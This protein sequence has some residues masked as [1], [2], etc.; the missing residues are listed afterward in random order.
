MSDTRPVTV[1]VPTVGR[2][3][4]VESC[5]ASLAACEPRAAEV[6]VADQS[7]RDDVREVAKRFESLGV[8]VLPLDVPSKPLA[9]NRALAEAGHEI[10]LVTDDDCTVD[11]AWVGAGWAA[12]SVDADAIVTGRVLPAGEVAAVPS[13]IEAAA[14]RDYTGTLQYGALYGGNMACN[15]TLVLAFGG[16][17]AR[18]EAAEDNDFCYRWLRA[19]RSLRYEPEL[20]VWHHAWR[21]PEELVLNYRAY[22]RGQG[23]FYGKHLR[24][25]DLRVAPFLFRDI[26]RGARGVAARLVRGRS[27]WPDPRTGLLRGVVVGLVRG[28]RSPPR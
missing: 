2:A 24:R 1:V 14:P 25:G 27:E 7:G 22:G 10:V 19:G 15:R 23:I 12:M 18:F 4:L 8:R 13:T 11:P 21:T 5:L 28:L 9:L 17:D 26:Y 20:V 3:G 6:I 16:F